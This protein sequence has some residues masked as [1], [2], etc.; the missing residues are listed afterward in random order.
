MRGKTQ[1]L[2]NFKCWIYI[3]KNL[4]NSCKISILHL[5]NIFIFL[6]VN[7]NKHCNKKY[8]LYIQYFLKILN[9]IKIETE[10]YSK[11]IHNIFWINNLFDLPHVY[12]IKLKL[13]Y[14]IKIKKGIFLKNPSNLNKILRLSRYKKISKNPIWLAVLAISSITT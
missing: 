7:K 5:H 11:Y 1:N 8:V 13:Q 12:N 14:K 4:N 9:I 2:L 3:W 10:R 6:N